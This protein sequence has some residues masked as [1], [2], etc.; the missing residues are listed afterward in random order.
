MQ[1]LGACAQCNEL[2][3]HNLNSTLGYTYYIQLRRYLLMALNPLTLFIYSREK[4]IY[5]FISLL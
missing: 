5:V 1:C 3:I 2:S 4:V